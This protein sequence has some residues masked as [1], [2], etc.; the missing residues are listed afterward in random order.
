[1]TYKK[2]S[3][4]NTVM[5]LINAENLVYADKTPFIARLEEDPEAEAVLEADFLP[6]DGRLFVRFEVLRPV[7]LFFLVFSS[8]IF[9]P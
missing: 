4:S 8:A 9:L 7:L 2:I 5:R 6:A 1:M 3:T